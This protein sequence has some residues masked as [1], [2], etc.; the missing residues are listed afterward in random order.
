MGGQYERLIG[1]FK[2]ALNKTI[3]NG[4]IIKIINNTRGG[5]VIFLTEKKGTRFLG[6]KFKSR[7]QGQALIG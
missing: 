6:G 3:G 1:L 7:M 2:R 5:I 4:V